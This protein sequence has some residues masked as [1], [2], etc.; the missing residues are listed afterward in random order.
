MLTLYYI[1]DICSVC[2]KLKVELSILFNWSLY[3]TDMRNQ[4]ITSLFGVLINKNAMLELLT[5]T[6]HLEINIYTRIQTYESLWHSYLTQ[7]AIISLSWCMSMCEI[8]RCQRN[9][10]TLKKWPCKLHF[11][12]QKQLRYT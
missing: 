3:Y 1:L 6:I 2:S 11:N 7:L 10:T 5:E 8:F 12:F 4:S 9:M